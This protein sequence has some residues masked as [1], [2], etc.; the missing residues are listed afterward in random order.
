MHE[1]RQVFFK[2]FF[3]R[4]AVFTN[5][6]FVKFRIPAKNLPTFQFLHLVQT[7]KVDFFRF[8]IQQS[9]MSNLDVPRPLTVGRNNQKRD[10]YYRRACN[11]NV[12]IATDAVI[13]YTKEIQTLCIQIFYRIC[14]LAALPLWKC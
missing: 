9:L 5:S 6:H 2:C 13:T 11:Q 4:K 1:K 14:Q 10:L 8:L 7:R 3:L 12:F